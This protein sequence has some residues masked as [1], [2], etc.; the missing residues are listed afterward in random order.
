MRTAI[1]GLEEV[2]V[3]A[4]VSKTVMPLRI[5]TGLIS[6]EQIV[7]LATGSHADQA[8]LSSS[9]HQTWAIKYGSGMRNDPRYT[10]SDVFETFPRPKPTDRLTE[11]GKT[12]DTERR[13]IMLR[14]DGIGLTK[15]YNLVNDPEI[16]DHADQDVARMRQIHVELDEAGDVGLRLGRRSAGPRFPHLP[17]DAALDGQPGR[18]GGDPGPVAG[19]EPP[20]RR[21]T[22]RGAAPG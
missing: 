22:G 18:A 8:V 20:S 11:I 16:T 5:Q 1:V 19:G 9:L 17:A 7:V 15:L 14:G 13:E 3:I 2:L 12:L 10:P 4:R 6:S 21:G